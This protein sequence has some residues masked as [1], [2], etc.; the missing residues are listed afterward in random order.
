MPDQEL[1]DAVIVE[2]AVAVG[3][4]I[5]PTPEPDY[6]ALLESEKAARAE[7]EAKLH[8]QGADYSALRGTIRSQVTRDIEAAKRF[9][10]IEQQIAT[11]AKVG[12]EEVAQEAATLR[13]QS[14]A[15]RR[16]AA[17]EAEWATLHAEFKGVLIG[18]DDK[19]V[20]DLAAAPEL[21]PVRELYREA[22]EAPNLTAEAR[23]RLLERATR[24]AERAVV[25]QKRVTTDAVV[26]PV[27]AP[28]PPKPRVPAMD[29]GAAAGGAVM[30]DADYYKE[31]GHADSKRAAMPF[32]KPPDHK[33]VQ[34]YLAT[35]K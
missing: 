16:Q 1:V 26:T 2:A 8:K 35:L 4:N 33:R 18:E 31:Y 25:Q 17:F 22:R 12:G 15:D 13:Q 24:L 10:A 20:M 11:I 3:G 6:K 19:A 7:L 30:S 14:E 23:L 21:A 29:T 32:G 9:D 28:T 27:V 34:K 5:L